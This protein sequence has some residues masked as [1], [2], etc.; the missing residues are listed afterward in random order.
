MIVL[1][2][3][4][5]LLSVLVGLAARGSPGWFPVVLPPC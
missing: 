3:L 2:L 4:P 1:A 5:V